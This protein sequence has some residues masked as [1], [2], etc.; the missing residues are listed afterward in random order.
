M[1]GKHHNQPE[2]FSTFDI[3]ELIPKNHMLRRIDRVLDLSFVRE[4]T[5]SFYSDSLGRPS[6]DP[7][8]FVRM[9]LQVLDA[10]Q[11][12]RSF[13]NDQNPRSSWRRDF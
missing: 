3:E 7:E 10:R 5:E 6:I 11:N 2:L 4:L 8:I 13:V 12:S 9:V 1:Q